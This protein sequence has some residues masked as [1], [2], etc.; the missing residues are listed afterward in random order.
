MKTP[1][2]IVL[3]PAL[4][5]IMPNTNKDIIEAPPAPPKPSRK[6]NISTGN[7]PSLPRI[8]NP[9]N[10]KQIAANPK[11]KKKAVAKKTQEPVKR[12]TTDNENNEQQPAAGEEIRGDG[13]E[14]SNSEDEESEK[15][16]RAPNYL[17][18]KDLQLCTLWLET[19]EDGQKGTNQTG[20]AF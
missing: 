7:D 19:T 12:T 6:R 17:E 11:P 15:K 8:S 16:T 3:D 2:D 1:V 4:Q 18:H 10:P 14:V 13:G 9:K 20:A 5:G